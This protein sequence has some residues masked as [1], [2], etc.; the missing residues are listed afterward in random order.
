MRGS[1]E[2]WGLNVGF[3]SRCRQCAKKRMTTMTFVTLEDMLFIT[4]IG[5][6]DV[7][8][9]FVMPPSGILK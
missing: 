7:V 8:K 3:S 9:H 1:W 2:V 6:N 4:E 5:N